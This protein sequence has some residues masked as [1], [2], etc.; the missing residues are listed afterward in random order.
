[1]ERD[2]SE[3]CNDINKASS[4]EELDLLKEEAIGMGHF[5]LLNYVYFN[6]N[7]KGLESLRDS[8]TPEKRGE[9]EKAISDYQKNGPQIEF[10]KRKEIGTLFDYIGFTARYPN[11][12]EALETFLNSYGHRG[13]IIDK[14]SFNSSFSSR[15][16]TYQC[17]FVMSNEN[18]DISLQA[19]KNKSIINEDF[20]TFCKSYVAFSLLQLENAGVD[21]FILT[22]IKKNLIKKVSEDKEKDLIS[23]D[24]LEPRYA[25]NGM[26][27]NKYDELLKEP[28]KLTKEQRK[29][30]LAKS[31]QH[32]IILSVSNEIYTRIM[33]E[34]IFQFLKNDYQNMLKLYVKKEKL[35]I[36]DCNKMQGKIY[37][38]LY[39][40]CDFTKSYSIKLQSGIIVSYEYSSLDPNI[41]RIVNIGLLKQKGIIQ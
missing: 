15:S 1:M 39:G 22:E 38:K 9:L 2:L 19:L 16:S 34:T 31:D 37:Q 28:N 7:L 23:L 18:N 21:K 29:E 13:F 26:N 4:Q 41:K 10:E 27:N 32:K 6:Q 17:Y 24:F 25:F 40:N 20:E 3:I 36:D 14:N 12:K 30:I 33:E 5:D 8:I 11:K 35:A